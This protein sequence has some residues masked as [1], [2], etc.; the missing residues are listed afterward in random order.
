MARL[1]EP[2]SVSFELQGQCVD[3]VWYSRKRVH[4]HSSSDLRSHLNLNQK[5]TAKRQG[6][7]FVILVSLCLHI[8]SSELQTPLKHHLIAQ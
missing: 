4:S 5:Q 2:S 3:E 1:K 6:V 7:F 8:S